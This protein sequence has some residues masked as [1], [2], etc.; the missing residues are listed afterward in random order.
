MQWMESLGSEVMMQL[1]KGCQPGGVIMCKGCPNVPNFGVPAC[2][3]NVIL[4]QKKIQPGFPFDAF[5]SG[6]PC[7]R[8]YQHVLSLL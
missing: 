8:T 5:H 3:A 6:K 4:T 2:N 7:N 1:R